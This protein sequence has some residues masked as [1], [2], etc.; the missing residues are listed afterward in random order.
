MIFTKY[1]I[2]CGILDLDISRGWLHV[3]GL[4]I[5]R[6][7]VMYG[8]FVLVWFGVLLGDWGVVGISAVS[9]VACGVAESECF[10]HVHMG[11][12]SLTY[13]LPGAVRFTCLA[14]AI[15]GWVVGGPAPPSCTLQ[16]CVN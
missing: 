3:P 10:S 6:F 15:L 5:V 12:W 8:M 13:S 9:G 1:I 4:R 7:G 11:S 2:V 16:K 14:S